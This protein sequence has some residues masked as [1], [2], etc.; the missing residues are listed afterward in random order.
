MQHRN[1]DSGSLAKV[2]LTHVSS[3]S[4]FCIFE[5]LEEFHQTCPWVLVV[6]KGEHSH[7]IPL[8]LKTPPSLRSELMKLLKN[9]E[10]D[11][12]DLTPRR[13]LRHAATQAY[14]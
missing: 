3:K 6:C 10:H 7:P 1:V 12:P 11:L 2:K 8:P 5:P 13:F 4:T 14:L 9:L